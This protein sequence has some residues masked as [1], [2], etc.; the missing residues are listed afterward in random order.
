S[1][2]AEMKSPVFSAEIEQRVAA[3]LKTRTFDTA[4]EDN[5]IATVV[6]SMTRTFDRRERLRQNG[7]AVLPLLP[8]HLTEPIAYAAREK[9]RDRLLADVKNVYAEV[10]RTLK[11]R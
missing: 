10:R 6:N 8:I 4:D 5:V 1:P 11:H 2:S 7:D 3:R 9:I